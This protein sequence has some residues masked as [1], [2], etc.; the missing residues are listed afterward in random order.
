MAELCRQVGTMSGCDMT[1]YV[2]V[3]AV[4][5]YWGAKSELG[6]VVTRLSEVY[7]SAKRDAVTRLQ[8]VGME[9]VTVGNTDV[10]IGTGQL[11][12]FLPS[13]SRCS[14]SQLSMVVQFVKCVLFGKSS[15][16]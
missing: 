15:A 11:I 13:N 4:Q 9:T 6:E 7:E 1:K 5:L 3:Y 16:S 10:N 8:Q 2:E 12:D 14:S